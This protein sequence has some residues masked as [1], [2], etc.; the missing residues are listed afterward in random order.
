[1]LKKAI[2][3]NLLENGLTSVEIE[4]TVTHLL[5][6]TLKIKNWNVPG[7][8]YLRK[9]HK[10]TKSGEALISTITGF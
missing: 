9:R 2:I 1:M 5:L 8:K 10:T 4:K 3:I 7:F 6:L